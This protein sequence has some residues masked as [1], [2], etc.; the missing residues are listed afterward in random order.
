M[1]FDFV[2]SATRLGTLVGAA[3]G[4]LAGL[5]SF[6]LLL[7]YASGIEIIQTARVGGM[8]TT[9]LKISPQLV[10][11]RRAAPLALIERMQTVGFAKHVAEKTGVDPLDLAASQY[12]GKGRLRVRQIGDGSLIEIRSKAADAETA[13]KIVAT[14][15]E[16]ALAE[17]RALVGP[18]H[19]LIDARIAELSR[20]RDASLA[21]A[22]ALS[23][24]IQESKD[25]TAL[26]SASE[27]LAKAQSASDALWAV[28]SGA[29]GPVSQDAE[30]FAE[31]ALARP[32]LSHWWQAALLG[33]FAGAALGFA[34]ALSRPGK[35]TDAQRAQWAA[36]E[37]TREEK[38]RVLRS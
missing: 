15:G 22:N 14:A 19:A 11:D 28:Q 21:I 1:T 7:N 17:E 32:I 35:S 6:V 16:L 26:S 4:G 33:A 8:E 2:S 3:V 12:G 37:S 10:I 13:L 34:I 27:A 24:A 38:T 30:V 36:R 29:V 25:A 5:V 18:L 23:A 9:Q 31:A 20:L